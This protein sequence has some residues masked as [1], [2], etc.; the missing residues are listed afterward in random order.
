METLEN[1]HPQDLALPLLQY[2]D[3]QVRCR[4]ELQQW[5]ACIAIFFPLPCYPEEANIYFLLLFS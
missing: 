3:Y 4:Q 2:L 1:P 5:E